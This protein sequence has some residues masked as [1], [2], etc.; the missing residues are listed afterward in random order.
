MLLLVDDCLKNMNREDESDV[1]G[2]KISHRISDHCQ[3]ID[4]RVGKNAMD[5]V[6]FEA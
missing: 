6:L 5:G 4:A 3:M 1:I 2:K